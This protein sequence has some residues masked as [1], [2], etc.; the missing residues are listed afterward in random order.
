MYNYLLFTVYHNNNKKEALRNT[1]NYYLF[2]MK[3]GFS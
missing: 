2:S 1:S 3:F